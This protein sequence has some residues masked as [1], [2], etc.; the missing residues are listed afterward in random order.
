L[1]SFFFFLFLLLR[2]LD[3]GNCLPYFTLLPPGLVSSLFLNNLLTSFK[4]YASKCPNWIA[5][6][7]IPGQHSEFLRILC[8]FTNTMS[9]KI[10]VYY[11]FKSFPPKIKLQSGSYYSFYI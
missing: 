3:Q 10:P 6:T 7:Y 2:R 5:V 4:S 8:T 11:P 9:V 1:F